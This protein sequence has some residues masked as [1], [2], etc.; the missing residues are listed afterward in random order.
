MENETTELTTEQL[1]LIC[2]EI[3]KNDLCASFAQIADVLNIKQTE[4]KELYMHLIRKLENHELQEKT[5]SN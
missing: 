1:Q 2:V 5:Q 3:L 4:A